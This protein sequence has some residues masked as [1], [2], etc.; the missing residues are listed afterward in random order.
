MSGRQHPFSLLVSHQEF[1]DN[2]ETCGVRTPDIVY[3]LSPVNPKAETTQKDIFRSAGYRIVYEQE[4]LVLANTPG[5]G[6][7]LNQFIGARD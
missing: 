6:V 5:H 1:I 2:Y 3:E 4:G 7:R